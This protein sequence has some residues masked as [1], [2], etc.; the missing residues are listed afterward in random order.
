MKMA[1]QMQEQSGVRWAQQKLTVSYWIGIHAFEVLIF[2]MMRF[3][4]HPNSKGFKEN[5]SLTSFSIIV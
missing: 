3:W 1:L 2:P 4:S 5:K